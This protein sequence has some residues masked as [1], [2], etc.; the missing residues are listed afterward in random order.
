VEGV[1]LGSLSEVNC[2]SSVREVEE[3]KNVLSEKRHVHRQKGVCASLGRR[4][5]GGGTGGKRG[6]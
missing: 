6:P 5:R 2:L 3:E 4:A 1:K